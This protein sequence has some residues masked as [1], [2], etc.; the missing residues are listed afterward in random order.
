MLVL[1]V[2]LLLGGLYLARAAWVVEP[3]LRDRDAKRLRRRM[4]DDGEKSWASTNLGELMWAAAAG[5][6]VAG[7]FLLVSSLKPSARDNGK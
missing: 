6:G 1:G 5:C 4:A 3:A 7:G 2:G